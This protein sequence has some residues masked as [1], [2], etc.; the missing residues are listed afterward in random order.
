MA[1]LVLP[2]LA[3]AIRAPGPGDAVGRLVSCHRALHPSERYMAV[4]GEMHALGSGERMQI[5]FDLYRRSSPSARFGRVAGPGLGV[6]HLAEPGVG[7]Y[8][9][10]KRITNLPGTVDYRVGVSLQWLAAD[11]SRLAGVVRYTP[12]CHQVELRPDLRVERIAM[13]SGPDAGSATYS[14]VVGNHGGGAA[15]RFNVTLSVGG[16]ALAPAS[17][18]GLA[19]GRRRAVTL[20]GPRCTPYTPLSAVVDPEHRVPEV[21][22]ANN[23][24]TTACPAA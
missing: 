15:R 24:R 22:D 1:A 7:S 18:N 14:V 6:W 8:R 5:R 9:F 16:M 20:V 2:A 12:V 11:G 13:A 19:V 3:L 10:V 23:A 17:V 4:E 21:V